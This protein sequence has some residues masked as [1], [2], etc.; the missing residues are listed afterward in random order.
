[1]ALANELL[2]GAGAHPDGERSL[3]GRNV[4]SHLGVIGLIEETV[5]HTA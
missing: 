3:A 5:I 2:Q 1:M 4:A